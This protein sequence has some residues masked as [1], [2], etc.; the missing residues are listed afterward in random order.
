MLACLSAKFSPLSFKPMPHLEPQ[1][2]RALF[3]PLQVSVS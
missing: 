1:G 2:L 3:G